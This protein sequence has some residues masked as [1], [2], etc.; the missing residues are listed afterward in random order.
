M[1]VGFGDFVAMQKTKANDN[2]VYMVLTFAY[3][4]LGLTL[5]GAFLNLIV[6]QKIV[7]DKQKNSSTFCCKKC[8]CDQVGG[9]YTKKC[10]KDEI[11]HKLIVDV[12]NS[13]PSSNHS[14]LKNLEHDKRHEETVSAIFYSY[15]LIIVLKIKKMNI[16][17][18]KYIIKI[19]FTA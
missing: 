14:F 12:T 3:I 16:Y 15:E 6:L 4:L 11:N 9:E 17:K 10:S 8:Q 2:L 7:H 5:V 1:F 19:R 18:L 13:S